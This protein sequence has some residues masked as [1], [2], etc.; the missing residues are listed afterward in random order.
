MFGGED[1]AGMYSIHRLIY[2]R[3]CGVHRLSSLSR[4]GIEFGLI[5]MACYGVLSNFWYRVPEY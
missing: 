5:G 1:L 2:E 3:V 4:P